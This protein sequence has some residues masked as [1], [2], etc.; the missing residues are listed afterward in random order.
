MTSLVFGNFYFDY[1]RYRFGLGLRLGFGLGLRL[2]LSL[3]LRVS[4]FRLYY[5]MSPGTERAPSIFKKNL[6]YAALRRHCD[7]MQILIGTLHGAVHQKQRAAAYTA[8][9]PS[10]QTTRIGANYIFEKQPYIFSLLRRDFSF[11]N[12]FSMQKFNIRKIRIRKYSILNHRD[13]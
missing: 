4:F 11:A 8:L 13:Y 10:L 2:G 12:F 1:Y 6:L 9:L 3:G 7:V 5:Q